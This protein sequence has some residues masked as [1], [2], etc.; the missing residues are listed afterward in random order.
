MPD[1]KI[2]VMGLGGS[3]APNSISLGALKIAMY[4]ASEAGAET[5]TFDLYSLN[6]PIYS[7]EDTQMPDAAK[8][9]IQAAA[10]ADAMIWCSPIYH[11]TISGA[12]KNA[13]DWLEA[14]STQNPPYLTN[15]V[16]G[17]LATRGGIEGLQAVNTMEFIVRALHGCA[18][19]MVMPVAKTSQAFDQDGAIGNDFSQS[20]L[21]SLGKEVVRAAQQL[22]TDGRCDYSASEL[23]SIK[24]DVIDVVEVGSKLS[25]PASDPPAW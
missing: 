4:G 15:K 8:R 23:N 13:I 2:K 5:E 18:I 20:Q 9:F 7:P 1:A 3:L 25:F 17:L 14:L 21:Q 16:V 6:L 10:E 24:S 22:C 11:G 19:P 12:F